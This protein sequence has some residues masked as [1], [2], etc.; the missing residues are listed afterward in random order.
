MRL[1][2]AEMRKVFYVVSVGARQVFEMNESGKG[3]K[4]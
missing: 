2:G 3:R 4:I 1:Q